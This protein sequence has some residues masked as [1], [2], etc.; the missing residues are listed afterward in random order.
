VSNLG[1]GWTGSHHAKGGF[2]SKQMGIK[3]KSTD[4]SKGSKRGAKGRIALLI[5][6]SAVYVYIIID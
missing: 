3:G 6:S 2:P 5:V 4:N 1:P